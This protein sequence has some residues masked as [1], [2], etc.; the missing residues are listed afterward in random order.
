[1]EEVA[2][3]RLKSRERA[4]EAPRGWMPTGLPVLGKACVT[5]ERN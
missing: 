3:N 5:N 4:H 1:M 2:E